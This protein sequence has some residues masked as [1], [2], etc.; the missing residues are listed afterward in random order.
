MTMREFFLKTFLTLLCA[1]GLL[2]LV[3]GYMTIQHVGRDAQ[4]RL[5]RLGY[6]E[7]SR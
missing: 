2:V 1:F 7:R 3:M 6:K 5:D 4:E